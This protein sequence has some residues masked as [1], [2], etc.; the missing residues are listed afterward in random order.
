METGVIKGLVAPP[1]ASSASNVDPADTFGAFAPFHVASLL[2][3]PS[4]KVSGGDPLTT[5]IIEYRSGVVYP[6]QVA[7]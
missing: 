4:S 5:L 2:L 3:Q 7:K 6:S 1:A